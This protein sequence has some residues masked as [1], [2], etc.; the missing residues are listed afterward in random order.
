[1]TPQLFERAGRAMF[2]DE[3]QPKMADALSVRVDSVKQWKKGRQLI[4]PDVVT[5][6]A[7]MMRID[8]DVLQAVRAEVLTAA[9]MVD[10]K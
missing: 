2:G 1:M 5:D 8:I 3:W 10:D 7:E 9:G 4:P 6:L